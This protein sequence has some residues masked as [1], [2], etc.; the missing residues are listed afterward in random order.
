[1]TTLD[2]QLFFWINGLAGENPWLD[3]AARLLV[4]DYFVPV[5][6][7]IVLV[8]LWFGGRSAERRRC[9]QRVVLAAPAALLLVNLIVFTGNTTQIPPERHRPYE[10]HPE[11]LATAEFFFYPPPDPAFPSNSTAVA[12]AIAGLLWRGVRRIGFLAGSLALGLG[13]ARIY[14]GVHYPL[15]VAAGMALGLLGSW[16]AWRILS[17]MEPLPSNILRLVRRLYLA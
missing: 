8:G 17:L 11:A 16:V 12:F 4:T 5:G 7:S 6:L 1:M 3:G 9:Y 14:A 2:H 13:L 10:D 15:D